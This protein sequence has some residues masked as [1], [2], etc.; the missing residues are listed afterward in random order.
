MAAQHLVY[1]TETC[2][3]RN[4]EEESI[5]APTDE[6]ERHPLVDIDEALSINMRL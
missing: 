3:Q 5:T 1:N 4:P 6:L 2:L